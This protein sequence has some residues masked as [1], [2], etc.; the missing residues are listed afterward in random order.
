MV[1]CGSLHT[2]V[3]A[4]LFRARDLFREQQPHQPH[5]RQAFLENNK[6]HSLGS[7]ICR[8][9]LPTATGHRR[10]SIASANRCHSRVAAALRKQPAA[11]HGWKQQPHSTI[12]REHLP[13]DPCPRRS[14]IAAWNRRRSRVAAECVDDMCVILCVCFCAQN[15]WMCVRA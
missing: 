5:E 9:Q 10:S 15:T 1:P 12:C 7:T 2:R 6:S 11:Q 4:I 3:Q 13:T 8:E 14:S